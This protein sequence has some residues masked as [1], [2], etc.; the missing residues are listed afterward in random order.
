MCYLETNKNPNN[1]K[2][3]KKAKVVK[4]LCTFAVLTA[5]T[6]T[7][8]L[9]ILAEQPLSYGN[10]PVIRGVTNPQE[11]IKDYS[12]KDASSSLRQM[13]LA[14]RLGLLDTQNSNIF[15]NRNL[16]NAQM[17]KAMVKIAGEDEGISDADTDS[18][19]KY[20]EK[21]I[22]LGLIKQ[23]DIDKIGEDKY[24]KSSPSMRVLNANLSKV[25]NI[26]T[27]YNTT[28]DKKATRLDLANLVYTNKSEILKKQGINVYTGQITNK[29]SLVEDGN[30]K[31]LIT[32]KLDKN[33]VIEKD[34][35]QK[36]KNNDKTNDDYSQNQ[37]EKIIQDNKDDST[38]V[39]YLNLLSQRDIP[40]LTPS[41]MTTD[42]KNIVE[43]SQV[44]IY[45][46][47]N[48]LLYIEQFTVATKEVAGVFESMI[49]SDKQTEEEENQ[50]SKTADNPTNIVK[51]KDYDNVAHLYKLHPDVK[52]M[53]YTGELG[54]NTAISK[55][56]SP[57]QLSYGQDVMLTLRNDVVTVIKAYV[58]VEEELN[59]YVEPE[60]QLINGIVSDITSSTISLTNNKSYTIGPDTLIT[61]GGE[62]Q[63]Y[64]VIKDGDRVKILFDD[65]NMNVP[66]KIEVEGMQRQADKIV[67]AKVGPYMLSHKT[68]NLKDVKELQNGQW[69]DLKHNIKSYEN[70]KIRG[71][72]YANSS[73][74]NVNKLKNY[75][76]QEIYA[77]IAKNQGIPTIEKGKIRIGD[78]LK[79]E[80]SLQD[81]NYSQNTL[82]IDTN[83][84]KFD[85]STIIVKDGNI[86]QSG[87]LEKNILSN[88]ETNLS[89]DAQIIIQTGS[90][91]NKDKVNDYPYKIYRAVLRDVFD[92]SI[93]L[94]NDIQN[95][96]KINNYYVWQGGVWSRPSEGEKT[97]RINFTEQ[98]KIYDYDNNKAMSIEEMRQSQNLLNE[99]S[100]RP[101]YHNRQVY[102]VTKDDVAVSISFVKSE[103]YGNVNSQ[104]MLA[105]RGVGAYQSQS[106]T[107]STPT[108][109]SKI[110]K[111]LIRNI[112]QYNSNTN[113][114][115]PVNPIITTDT[116]TQEIK[117]TQVRKIINLDKAMII[118]NGKTVQKTSV[119]SL[120]DK[121]LTIIFRQTRDKKTTD[122][123]EEL[124]AI[125][126]IAN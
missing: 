60:S 34:K 96:K 27:K 26:Q 4:A 63:D 67:K 120:K 53:Q 87:S 40:I 35:E 58:P 29:S 97:P 110:P 86:V 108:N 21:A 113:K 2:K 25:L 31:T 59:S 111:L 98:T 44:N 106:T 41:G 107:G 39:S 32:V 125:T 116:A 52:I 16:T 17:L 6:I 65:L 37:V 88:V 72:V 100:S 74:V 85:E 77:V 104:N 3:G 82:Q 18:A 105:A 33:M 48:T 84:V 99:S 93:L 95:G 101:A 45:S 92:Y 22:G 118:V 46:K 69:V 70:I 80:N 19:S 79:F 12:I 124:D 78:S 117:K 11:T 126:V 90:S 94:G 71:N 115:E 112:Y 62:I 83:L 55:P 89:K 20:K 122:N 76:N 66:S 30:N 81:V 123:I 23:E 64:K 119:D 103:G 13:V 73:K 54:D 5:F 7:S 109:T 61:K 14:K 10:Y 9:T 47:N 42:T 114:L 1:A 38:T 43:E 8:N 24:M 15:P 49:I 56:V 75:K 36:G 102:V 28:P 121:D 50:K 57:N 91:F 51:I 68:L